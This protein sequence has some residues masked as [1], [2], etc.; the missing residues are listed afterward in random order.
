MGP[1]LYKSGVRGGGPNEPQVHTRGPLL[2][3]GS[4]YCFI[5]LD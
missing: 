2:N 1:L 4:I 3:G 5:G